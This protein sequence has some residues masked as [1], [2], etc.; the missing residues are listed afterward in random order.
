MKTILNFALIGL[1][2]AGWLSAG[3]LVVFWAGA[4]REPYIGAAASILIAFPI[5]IGF[6]GAGVGLLIWLD[7]D[8]T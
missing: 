1:L 3:L 6:I 8:W 7:E 2:C 4:C 5:F